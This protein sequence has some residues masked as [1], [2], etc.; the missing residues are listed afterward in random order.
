MPNSSL[1]LFPFELSDY[2]NYR[3]EYRLTVYQKN[4]QAGAIQEHMA[5]NLRSLVRA[6]SETTKRS[7]RTDIYLCL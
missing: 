3:Q 5:K 6:V 7:V 4:C 2:R 1:P